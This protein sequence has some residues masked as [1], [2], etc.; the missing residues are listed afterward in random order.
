MLDQRSEEDYTTGVGD[1]EEGRESVQVGS[2]RSSSAVE[3]PQSSCETRM[4]G[5]LPTLGMLQELVMKDVRNRGALCL[6]L[7][8]SSLSE[9]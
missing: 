1:V 9:W 3:L 2:D 4:I 8:S 5:Y 6:K 7:D